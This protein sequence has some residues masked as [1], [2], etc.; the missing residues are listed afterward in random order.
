MIVKLQVFENLDP[1]SSAFLPKNVCF[2]QPWCR[3]NCQHEN[4]VKNWSINTRIWMW[5]Q[6]LFGPK[7]CVLSTNLMQERCRLILDTQYLPLS[8]QIVSMKIESK[9]DPS[10]TEFKC[11]FKYDLAPKCVF[12]PKLMQ[13]RCRLILN[14][15]YLPYSRPQI[16]NKKI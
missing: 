7:I 10:T 12:S 4:R 15:Q 2:S 5:I 13:E 8:P 6:V 3:S 1:N 9:I 14:A 16:G 11:E